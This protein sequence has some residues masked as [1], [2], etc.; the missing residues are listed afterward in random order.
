V[1]AG[2][3]SYFGAESRLYISMWP[4]IVKIQMHYRTIPQSLPSEV[5]GLKTELLKKR[6]EKQR[7]KKTAVE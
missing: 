5:C 3:L 7:K 4:K 2:W 6:K 1:L